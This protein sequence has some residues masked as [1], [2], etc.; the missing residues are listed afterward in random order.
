MKV[1][2]FEAGLDEAESG[3]MPFAERRGEHPWPGVAVQRDLGR[4][5]REWLHT[6]GAGA[7]AASTIAGMHTRRYHGLL[8]AAL[9][10]PRSRHV[11]LSHI[12][13]TVLGPAPDGPVSSQKPRTVSRYGAR[14]VWDLAKHQFPGVDPKLGPFHLLRFDQDPLPRWTYALA[15]GELEVTLAMVRG[16]NA[17]VLRYAF[18]GKAPLELRLRPLIAA[19]NFHQLQR[20]HGGM[21]QRVE[22]RPGDPSVTNGAVPPGEMRV[23]PRKDL[24]R[25]CFRYEGTFV[26]SPD[27]WRRFEYLAERDRGLDYEEDLWTPG[28][29]EVPLRDGQPA[30][31]MA[32]VERLPEG[33]P[34]AHLAA[35]EKALAGADPGPARPLAVRRLSIAADA[36]RADLAKKPGVIAGYPWFEVW[37]RD[38]L[39]AL[40]GLYLVPER[41]A[42]AVRVVRELIAGMTDGVVP[43]RLPEP[44][45]G[46]PLAPA[47]DYGSADATLW[48]FEAGRHLIDALG[49]AD[50]FITGELFPA[51]CEAFEAVLRGTRNAIHLSA[52][53]LFVAGKEGDALTWMDARVAGRP[54]TSRAGCAVEATALWAS[55]CETLRRLAIGRDDPV[56]ADRAQNACDRARRAFHERFWC[57]ESRYPYDVVGESDTGARDASVRPNAV[58]A[59]AVAPECFTAERARLVLERARRDL[60]T[61]AGLRTL[62]PGD[63]RY[64]GRYGGDVK[65]RDGAYHQGTAWPWLL[66]FY[67]RAALRA[68]FEEPAALE[69]LVLAAARNEIALGH[70]AELADGDPPHAPGG[71]LAHAANVAELLRVLA[72]DLP[73]RHG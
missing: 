9:D 23:R 34:A 18:S 67:A 12:D 60:L 30:W 48:L 31:L 3:P 50:P 39:I 55:G 51:L 29:F 15:D 6:N 56:L 13:T 32:A 62:A 28:V 16:E 43:G 38:T 4:A 73:R 22:L 63:A 25:I 58:V 11:F 5:R 68:G 66:G 41:R 59:L 57:A 19:R 2:A 70:T 53:G 17:V 33:E 14:P 61:P 1:A 46:G 42:E 8:V 52:D 44:A 27:W 69:A 24:P 47:A 7:F 36:F 10:P 35:A 49:D 65:A 20:E 37:G 40:P 72:W 45:N 71:C 26:G 21:V 54:V 64:V